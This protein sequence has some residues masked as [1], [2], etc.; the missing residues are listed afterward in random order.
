MQKEISMLSSDVGLTKEYL[1]ATW[2]YMILP[3]DLPDV[4]WTFSTLKE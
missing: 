3:D 4:I 2:F 1:T